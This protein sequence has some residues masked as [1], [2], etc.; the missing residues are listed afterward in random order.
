MREITVKRDSG[1]WAWAIWRIGCHQLQWG[2]CRW[3]RLW[4]AGRHISNFVLNMLTLRWLLDFQVEMSS[5][6]LERC[7]EFGICTA[8]KILSLDEITKGVS[9]IK[10]PK[11]SAQGHA[12][13]KRIGTREGRSKGDWERMISEVGKARECSFI[14]KS[15]VLS[16]WE[17]QPVLPDASNRSS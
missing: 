15:G 6:Q 4:G 5:S 11:D 8:F 16:R 2:S 13:I 1:T 17:E 9:L 12:N 7:V 3:S 10:R 14:N